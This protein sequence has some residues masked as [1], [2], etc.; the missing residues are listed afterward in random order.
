M[1]LHQNLKYLHQCVRLGTIFPVLLSDRKNTSVRKRYGQK[2]NRTSKTGTE[3]CASKK[4]DVVLT[5]A[6]YELK[7]DGFKAVT[8]K[9]EPR[10]SAT[11]TPRGRGDDVEGATWQT[12][13]VS[14][15]G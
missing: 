14:V 11:W 8:A 6:F 5:S 2:T 15:G 12:C 9:K 1:K 10:G 3:G 4:D 7:F 13:H